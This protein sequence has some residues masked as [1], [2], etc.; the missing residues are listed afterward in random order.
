LE[1]VT[2]PNLLI[3]TV[4]TV[5]VDSTAIH[6][7]DNNTIVNNI[8]KNVIFNFKDGL[9]GSSIVKDKISSSDLGSRFY[10][11]DWADL[12]TVSTEKYFFIFE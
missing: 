8:A 5:E 1:T 10:A 12:S 9:H 7:I 6:T 11:G 4:V 2:F 3:N